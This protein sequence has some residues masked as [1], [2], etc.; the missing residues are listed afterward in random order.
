MT[1]T[2][3]RITHKSS[4]LNA[5]PRRTPP[6]C[7]QHDDAG[8]P[9]FSASLLA[10][11]LP[12]CYSFLLTKAWVSGILLLMLRRLRRI[13]ACA[14]LLS[15]SF[16]SVGG[17]LSV[18]T[19]GASMSTCCG[20]RCCCARN[21]PMRA[22]RQRA[23]S[24]SCASHSLGAATAQHQGSPGRSLCTCGVSRHPSALST[25][26]IDLRFDLVTSATFGPL[27]LLSFRLMDSQPP[28][29]GAYLLPPDHPPRPAS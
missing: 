22:A 13:Q 9:A 27:P 25:A 3:I 10:R 17:C 21:C 26:R 5:Y 24:H 8:R 28:T 16:L 19:R 6:V 11:P 4:I 12:A 14:V 20:C 2:F 1:S 29:L 23:A 18:F 15:L 7:F